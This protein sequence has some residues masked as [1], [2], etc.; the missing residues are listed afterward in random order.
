MGA[1]CR[2][3]SSKNLRRAWAQHPASVMEPCFRPGYTA[4]RSPR[5]HLLERC[6]HRL[7][8]R[9]YTASTVAAAGRDLITDFSDRDLIDLSQMDADIVHPYRQPFHFIGTAA[10]DETAGALEYQVVSGTAY[11]YGDV[12]GDG[13]AD[14]PIAQAKTASLKAS[15]LK[16]TSTP[17]G[18]GPRWTFRLH[19][20]FEQLQQT[21]SQSACSPDLE[22]DFKN[23][24]R[25]LRNCR[26]M[27]IRESVGGQSLQ[28]NTRSALDHLT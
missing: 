2:S 12:N 20:R 14:F 26:L 7:T 16:L 3:A 21:C 9:N 27:L 24:H 15:D 19:W 8:Y 4:C 1:F 22:I 13:A 6:R 23:F 18:G 5:R 25:S 28:P 17:L 10:L 11:V